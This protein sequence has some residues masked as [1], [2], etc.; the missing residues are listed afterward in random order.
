MVQVWPWVD[1]WVDGCMDA[2]RAPFLQMT[3]PPRDAGPFWFPQLGSQWKFYRGFLCGVGVPTVKIPP[4]QTDEHPRCN[5]TVELI[6]RFLSF[7]SFLLGPQTMSAHVVVLVA[8]GECMYV[9]IFV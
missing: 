8:W 6:L 1:G 7:F 4:P 5:N 2:W 3:P 9:R